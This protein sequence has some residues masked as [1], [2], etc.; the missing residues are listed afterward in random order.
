MKQGNDVADH[1]AGLGVRECPSGEINRIR[2]LDSKAWW[3]QERMIQALMLLPKRGRHPNERT[4]H[5]ETPELK[6]PHDRQRQ[7]GARLLQHEVSRR[8]PMIECIKCGQFWESTATNLILAQG[9]CPG[10][11]IYGDQ[12]Y[13]QE[14]P[15]I[16]PA[17]RGPIWWGKHK[18]HKSHRAAWYRG[19][20]FCSGCGHFSLK[21]Q[22][23][24]GLGKPCSHNPTSRYCQM[25]MKLIRHGTKR[26]GLTDWPDYDNVP[27]KDEPIIANISYQDTRWDTGPPPRTYNTSKTMTGQKIAEKKGIFDFESPSQAKHH[28]QD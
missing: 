21:G 17:K 16:I 19:V 28:C 24:R 14:R 20:L 15:W 12:Q 8:G 27:G 26:A 25:T 9:M 6:I 18:L 7:A 22:S 2:N 1:H 5:N 4:Y 3:F 10:P 13:K 23:L 11:K